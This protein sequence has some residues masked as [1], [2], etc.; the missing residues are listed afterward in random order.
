[1]LLNIL[2]KTPIL[3]PLVYFPKRTHIIAVQKFVALWLL[4]SSPVLLAILLSPI[5]ADN[6]T[7]WEK[8]LSKWQESISVSELYIYVASFLSPVLYILYERYQLIDGKETIK[9]KVEET[10]GKIFYGYR[11]ISFLALILLFLTVAAYSAI[12]AGSTNFDKTFLYHFISHLSPW[13]Y[14][15]AVYCWYLSIL[16]GINIPRDFVSES[17]QSEIGLSNNLKA[18]LDE[19]G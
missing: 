9:E 10:F 17:R 1:M 15:Y 14:L 5:P 18:R 8:L 7:I 4:S 6:I 16:D 12:K 19:R 2:R 3:Q 11:L 13:V